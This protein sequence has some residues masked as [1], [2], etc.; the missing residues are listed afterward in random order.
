MS[1]RKG[2]SISPDVTKATGTGNI[3]TTTTLNKAF[4]LV[5]VTI[6]LSVATANNFT[7]TKD[8]LNGAVYDAV[9]QTLLGAGAT[10]FVFIPDEDLKFQKGDEIAVAWTNDG[11]GVTTYGLEITTED[12]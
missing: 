2:P 9:L 3:A 4:R 11:P 10:Y 7:I 12:I 6:K 1:F 8:A 5:S